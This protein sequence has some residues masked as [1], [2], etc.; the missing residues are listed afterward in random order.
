VQVEA[1]VLG[2]PG[3]DVGVLVGAVVV[4]D[5]VDVQSFGGLAVDGAQELEELFVAVAGQA[6]AM[7]LP[8]SAQVEQDGLVNVNIGDVTI[9]KDVNIAIAAL[10]AANICGV[11]VGPVAVLGQAVDASGDTETVCTNRAGRRAVTI[12][13]N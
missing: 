5:Q 9:L 11:D 8:A 12:S 1:G 4:Q 6:L 7:A 2:Q 3:R 13:Q 10:V